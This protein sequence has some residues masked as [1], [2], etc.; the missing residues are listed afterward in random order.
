MIETGTMGN[1]GRTV[2]QR[3]LKDMEDHTG[4]S[5]DLAC[6]ITE[7]DTPSGYRWRYQPASHHP[8]A[9]IEA[10]IH[11]AKAV[12]EAEARNSGKT[13]LVGSTPQPDPALYVFAHGHPDTCTAAIDV[14]FEFTPAGERIRRPGPRTAVRH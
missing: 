14:M 6:C 11:V 5:A 4:D 3:L 12:A 10:M 13:Y 9:A 8:N 7:E 2:M 1:S